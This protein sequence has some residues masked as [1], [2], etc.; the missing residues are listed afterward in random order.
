MPITGQII[1]IT[2]Q[3][4]S[5]LPAN[6]AIPRTRAGRLLPC[7]PTTITGLLPGRILPLPVINVITVITTLLRIPVWVVTSM[8]T[9]RL[10]PHPPHASAQFPTDCQTCHTT[11]A[12][13]PSTFNHDGQ[14]FPIYSGHHAGKWTLC[15][16]CHTNASNYQVFSCIDCHAHSNQAQVN[17]D[18]QGVSGYS[19]NSVACYNCHPTGSSGGKLMHDHVIE[20][21]RQH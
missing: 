16:D 12:W 1:R 9:T 20:N 17:S 6:P 10:R 3:P 14:Y 11:T 19:Y 18:H 4:A 13:I 21:N 8:I 7:R 2:L 5:Q 15:A